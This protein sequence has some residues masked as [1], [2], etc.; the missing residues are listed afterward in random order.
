MILLDTC[1]LIWLV[2]TP[3]V[4]TSVAHD[5]I[6][7]NVGCLFVSAISAFEIAL[8]TKNKGLE[9]P[10]HPKQWFSMALRLHGLR[11]MPISASIAADAALLPEIHRDPFDRIII[12]TAL[13]H[14]LAVVTSDKNICKYPG[15]DVL[16]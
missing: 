8:K 1:A 3:E 16:W 12:A 7:D 10:M 4:M 9:L 13:A 15:I 2:Q 14:R 5:A 6:S 11:E